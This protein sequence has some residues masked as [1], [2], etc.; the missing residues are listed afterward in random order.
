MGYSSKQ[1]KRPW[2]AKTDSFV[3]T[4]IPNGFSTRGKTTQNEDWKIFW[5]RSSTLICASRHFSEYQFIHHQIIDCKSFHSGL[6][7]YVPPPPPESNIDTNNDVFL[8]CISFQIFFL[9]FPAFV[10]M[11]RKTNRDISAFSS[12][13]RRKALWDT[14]PPRNS[15][16]SL[17]PYQGK[18]KGFHMPWS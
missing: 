15:R 12:L 11:K 1:L 3:H 14:M 2:A 16:V 10:E 13:G 4:F 18:P 7:A 9:C 5:T 17:G 6:L 8:T